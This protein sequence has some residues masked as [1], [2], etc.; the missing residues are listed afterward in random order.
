MASTKNT[1]AGTSPLIDYSSRTDNV[2]N[3]PADTMYITDVGYLGDP[4]RDVTVSS[5]FHFRKSTARQP[6]YISEGYHS[7][8]MRT[9]NGVA[10][11]SVKAVQNLAIA[12]MGLW[13]QEWRAL[14][15]GVPDISNFTHS[16]SQSA[17]SATSI[18]TGYHTRGY[19]QGTSPATSS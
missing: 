17:T 5:D 15:P 3:R 12:H 2:S 8:D 10:N 16:R 4:W 7:N 18:R 19:H 6:I 13:V 1:E 11:P 14:H 9:P